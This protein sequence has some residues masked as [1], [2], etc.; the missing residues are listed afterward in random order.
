MYKPWVTDQGVHPVPLRNALTSP[1]S[2]SLR[3]DPVSTQEAQ[4]SNWTPTRGKVYLKST[5]FRD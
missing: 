1:G 5:P 3:P 4:S 2:T